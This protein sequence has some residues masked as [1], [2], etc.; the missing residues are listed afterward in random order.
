MPYQT[1]RQLVIDPPPPGA[2]L[3]SGPCMTPQLR[4][5]LETRLG[6]GQCMKVIAVAGAGKST[7]LREYAKRNKDM[8]TLYVTFNK[9]VQ[10]HQEEAYALAGLE[11][12]HVRT[13]SSLA[14]KLTIPLHDHDV[15]NALRFSDAAGACALESDLES[16]RLTLEAYMSS[17]DVSLSRAHLRLVTGTSGAAATKVLDMATRAWSALL[18]GRMTPTLAALEKLAPR[19]EVYDLVLLDEAHDVTASQL[20]FALG[21]G[22]RSV[23]VYD[24]RQRINDWRKC[25]EV[26]VLDAL[27]GTTLPLTHSWRFGDDFARS[28]GS[29]VDGI[30]PTTHFSPTSTASLRGAPARRTEICSFCVLPI[31]QA[32]A[33]KK[34][35]AV[36]GSTNLKIVL[37]ALDFVEAHP[38]FAPTITFASGGAFAHVHALDGARV[39][40]ELLLFSIGAPVAIEPL[41]RFAKRLR[42]MAC[43]RHYAVNGL[44][45]EASMERADDD[46][47]VGD[48]APPP[49]GPSWRSALALFDALGPDRLRRALALFEPDA[50]E[51]ATSLATFSTI[52]VAKGLSW[53]WV[54]L[55]DTFLLA[56][57]RY[58]LATSST[59][60]QTTANL[61]YVAMTRAEEKLFLPPATYSAMY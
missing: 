25:V 18:C 57:H 36:L 1:P 46:T 29:F 26:A 2:L 48:G 5:I 58:N 22:A 55:L 56:T 40:R 13:L 50:R 4:A 7:A 21:V 9:S 42:P 20:R 17:A 10:E 23:V 38:N 51:P 43:L 12:V 28:V 47:S 33:A 53:P 19:S 16:V 61:A 60:F 37:A 15:A 35:V 11:H 31:A 27:P 59:S 54:A 49:S 44:D 30:S 6:P 24:P 52:H 34:H 3:P 32:V 8:R 41:A 39:M 14:Y 45:D